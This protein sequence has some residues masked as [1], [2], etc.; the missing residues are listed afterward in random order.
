MISIDIQKRQKKKKKDKR[1]HK[2]LEA[3]NTTT[4]NLTIM[5]F[6]EKQPNLK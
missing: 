2:T 4:A 6:I 1:K 3:N 5:H